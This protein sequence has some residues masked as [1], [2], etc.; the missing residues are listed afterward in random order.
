M[1]VQQLDLFGRNA[2]DEIAKKAVAKYDAFAKKFDPK[3]TTDECWTPEPVYDA[4]LGWLKERVDLTGKTIR[5]PFHP[6][7]DYVEEAKTYT[8]DDVVVDNP[9]FSILAEIRRYYIYMGIPYFL[10]APHLTLFS[11]RGIEDTGIITHANITYANGAKVLTS[12]VSNMFGTLRLM[13]APQM[14][15]AIEIAEREAKAQSMPP[16]PPRYDYPSNVVTSSILARTLDSGVVLKIDAS[17]CIF[18]R[19]LE[20]QKPQKKSIFGGGFLVSDERA[21]EVEDL[22][23]RA[24]EAKEA[25][26]KKEEEEEE[27]MK[28]EL[29]E[30]ERKVIQGLKKKES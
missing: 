28:W 12:F 6:D 15:E 20:A 30:M 9:P 11:G 5:R 29:S 22:T 7:G 26:A 23:A 21:K 8:A 16:P 27:V 19:R 10:F 24:K 17:E 3:K 1:R 4:I 2:R 18:I 13:T 25:R 14:A